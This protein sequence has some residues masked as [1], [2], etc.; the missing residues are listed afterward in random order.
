MR[1]VR[2]AIIAACIILLF[3]SSSMRKRVKVR[4]VEGNQLVRCAKT[5][6]KRELSDTETTSVQY[7]RPLSLS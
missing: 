6:N 7:G 5:K 4:G 2:P 3:L 1:T